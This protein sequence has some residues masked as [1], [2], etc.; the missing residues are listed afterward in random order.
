MHDSAVSEQEAENEDGEKKEIQS[1]YPG[2]NGEPT[3]QNQSISREHAF[4]IRSC[5]A[6]HNTLWTSKWSSASTNDKEAKPKST[7]SRPL[8]SRSGFE[9]EE[10]MEVNT[11]K[12]MRRAI[13]SM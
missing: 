10:E 8:E 1:S 4:R 12:R 3:L 9:P 7:A 13:S 6:T 11:R 2:A 5:T